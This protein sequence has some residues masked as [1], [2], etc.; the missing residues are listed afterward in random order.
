MLGR[1]LDGCSSSSSNFCQKAAE[2]KDDFTARCRNERHCTAVAV[3]ADVLC[4]VWT[5]N[6]VVGVW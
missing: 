1:P 5:V 2:F 3:S 4:S 6:I